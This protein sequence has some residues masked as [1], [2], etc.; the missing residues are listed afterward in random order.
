MVKI[1]EVLGA[2]VGVLSY[3]SLNEGMEERMCLN[4]A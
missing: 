4:G 2:K 3:A 1:E